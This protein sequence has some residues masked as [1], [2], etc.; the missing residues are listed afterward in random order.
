MT[1]FVVMTTSQQTFKNVHPDFT[2]T[3]VGTGLKT[4]ENAGIPCL[5]S[6][7]DHQTPY[8]H[9]DKWSEVINSGQD[10]LPLFTLPF[11]MA[12]KTCF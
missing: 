6:N 2:L 9:S 10:Q 3:A 4:H 8:D 11:Q 7:M 5:L 1:T 12:L